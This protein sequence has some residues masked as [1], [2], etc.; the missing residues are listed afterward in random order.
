M[1]SKVLRFLGFAGMVALAM[2]AVF[3]VSRKVNRPALKTLL[4]A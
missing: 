2:V 4:S 1:V 3:A